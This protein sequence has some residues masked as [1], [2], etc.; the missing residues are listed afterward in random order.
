MTV[1]HKK[2]EGSPFQFGHHYI[3]FPD[4]GGKP[5]TLAHYPTI[6]ELAVGR[7]DEQIA[8]LDIEEFKKFA[9]KVLADELIEPPAPEWHD[10]KVIRCREGGRTRQFLRADSSAGNMVHGDWV[11]DIGV[12]W[13]HRDIERHTADIEIVVGADDE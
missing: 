12:G 3:N 5:I 4:Y 1:T 9:R 7:G 6:N 11:S 13:S 10:A 8:D 2:L